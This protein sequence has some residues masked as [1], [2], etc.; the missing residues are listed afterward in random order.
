MYFDNYAGHMR[1]FTGSVFRGGGGGGEGRVK[2]FCYAKTMTREG[3]A[4]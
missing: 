2:P 4:L 3:Q 1:N